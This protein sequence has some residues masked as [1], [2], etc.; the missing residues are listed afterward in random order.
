MRKD[1]GICPAAIL[2]EKKTKG[3]SPDHTAMFGSMMLFI[4]VRALGALLCFHGPW[5]VTTMPMPNHGPG[6]PDPGLQI[7]LQAWPWTCPITTNLSDGLNS[8]LN[9][10]CHKALSLPDDHKTGNKGC[11]HHSAHLPILWASATELL[12][13]PTALHLAPH[14]LG[15]SWLMLLPDTD[16][17]Q[18]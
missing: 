15:S 16:I 14:P 2:K 9:L 18:V 1:W 7:E 11:C 13:L 3:W 6:A 17:G 10:T 4:L 8:W 12:T 5:P